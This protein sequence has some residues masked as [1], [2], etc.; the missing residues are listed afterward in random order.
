MG[1]CRRESGARQ[2]IV[3]T[4]CSSEHTRHVG[5]NVSKVL[6]WGRRVYGEPSTEI[7]KPAYKGVPYFRVAVPPDTAD[8]LLKRDGVDLRRRLLRQQWCCDRPWFSPVDVV[9]VGDVSDGF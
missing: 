5:V 3:S 8:T 4:H 1:C 9:V 7:V 6:L 2:G